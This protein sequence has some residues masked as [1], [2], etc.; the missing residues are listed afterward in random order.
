LGVWVGT[1]ES[2]L[3]KLGISCANSFSQIQYIARVKIITLNYCGL[4]VTMRFIFG[5][6]LMDFVVGPCLLGKF[7]G[8]NLIFYCF[9]FLL[10]SIF[11][12][13]SKLILSFA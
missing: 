4:L 7:L 8:Y 12:L 10:P 3:F 6:F 5:L 9:L 2:Q 11:F 13:L 1:G